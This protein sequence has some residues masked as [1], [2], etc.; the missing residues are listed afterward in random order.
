MKNR[1]TLFQNSSYGYPRYFDRHLEI[2]VYHWERFLEGGFRPF[3]GSYRRRLAHQVG[4]S[5]SFHL[6]GE[7]VRGEFHSIA[8]DGSLNLVLSDGGVQNFRS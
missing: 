6:E 3:L 5:V 7:P 4:E 2:Y 8:D 1:T